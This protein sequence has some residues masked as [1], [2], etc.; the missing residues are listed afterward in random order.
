[1]PQTVDR[2]LAK[3]PG[4]VPRVYDD[5]HD[6]MPDVTKMMMDSPYRPPSAGAIRVDAIAPVLVVMPPANVAPQAP[7]KPRRVPVGAIVMLACASVL[8]VGALVAYLMVP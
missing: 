6:L 8:F 1:M 5:D 7:A 4:G 3:A 2:L